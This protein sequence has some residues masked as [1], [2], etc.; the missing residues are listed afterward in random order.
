MCR[1]DPQQFKSVLSLSRRP[2][3]T[4][5]Q[6]STTFYCHILIP[7]WKWGYSK[8]LRNLNAHNAWIWGSGIFAFDPYKAGLKVRFEF[9]NSWML[10]LRSWGKLLIS[11]IWSWSMPPSKADHHTQICVT[12]LHLFG[13]ISILLTSTDVLH[14]CRAMIYN[15]SNTRGLYAILP[16]AFTNAVKYRHLTDKVFN[17]SSSSLFSL[18]WGFSLSKPAVSL[19]K[20]KNVFKCIVFLHAFY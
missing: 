15:C 2:W 16:I 14:H 17:L 18:L 13:L 20:E 11:S 1:V 4:T 3:I 8:V 7:K 19:R 12:K 10:G 9:F 5:L 6:H